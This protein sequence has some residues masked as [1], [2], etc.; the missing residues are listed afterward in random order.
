M[1]NT[2]LFVYMPVC[3]ILRLKIDLLGRVLKILRR[4]ASAGL[5]LLEALV[6]IE[7]LSVMPF[8]KGMF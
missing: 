3:P 1:A 2:N 5:Q 6:W 8:G 7:K 4:R